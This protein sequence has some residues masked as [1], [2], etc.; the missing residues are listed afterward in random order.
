MAGLVPNEACLRPLYVA[1]NVNI[2]SRSRWPV[3]STAPRRRFRRDV[4]KGAPSSQVDHRTLVRRFR[5]TDHL[6]GI[7]LGCDDNALANGTGEPGRAG[8]DSLGAHHQTVQRCVERVA[9][10][11]SEWR[12]SMIGRGRARSQRS[13]QRPRHG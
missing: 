1:E 9:G 8:A 6:R 12:R 3:G 13:P 2:S 7:H 5:E 11:W 10:V 4:Q